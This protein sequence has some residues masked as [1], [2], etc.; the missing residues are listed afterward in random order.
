M[1]ADENSIRFFCFALGTAMSAVLFTH[2]GRPAEDTALLQQELEVVTAQRDSA[3]QELQTIER[4]L[5][6]LVDSIM[7]TQIRHGIS[8]I[9]AQQTTRL[10]LHYGI[11]ANVPPILLAAV[12]RVESR[13]KVG[14]L[15]AVGESGLF[16]VRPEMWWDF[17]TAR[18]GHWQ[19]HD[20]A[21]EVC[22]GAHV[23]G[24]RLKQAKGDV[25]LALSLYNTGHAQ[26]K[27][28][29]RYAQRVMEGS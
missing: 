18:C 25:R 3:K 17:V 24:F 23:L 5:S 14:V 29:W 4:F 15:G 20:R 9:E 7:A 12:A 19:R 8:P 21:A 1:K 13:Y 26:S 16:Q 27:A 22:A 2:A 10:L 28:G 6:P 11:E